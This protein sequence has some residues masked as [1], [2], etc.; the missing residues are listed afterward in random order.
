MVFDQ[1]ERIRRKEKMIKWKIKQAEKKAYEEKQ[2]QARLRTL[3][4]AIDRREAHCQVCLVF[5]N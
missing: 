4:N 2:E 3:Q 5:L 1:A